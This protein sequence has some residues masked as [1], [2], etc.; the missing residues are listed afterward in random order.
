MYRTVVLIVALVV[1]LML[2]GAAFAATQQVEAEN[3]KMPADGYSI[4]SDTAAS[5][6]KYVNLRKNRTISTSFSGAVD[7]LTVRAKGRYYG[8]AWPRMVVKLDGTTV[9]SRLANS[10]TFQNFTVDLST[11]IADAS[12]NLSLSFTNNYS[13]RDLHVDVVTVDSGSTAPVTA[14]GVNWCPTSPE[15]L[16]LTANEQEMFKLHNQARSQNGVQELCVDSRLVKAAR[17]HAQDMI[18]NDYFSHTSQD[19]R[20]PGD[21]ISAQG[22]KWRTYGENVAYGSGSYGTPQNVFDGW[23]NSE[24]HRANILSSNF[25]DV[26]IGEAIGEY[27]GTQDTHMWVADFGAQ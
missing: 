10:S 1:S 3:M 27:K 16:A 6:G 14:D 13:Y 7:K 25:K 21:R 4:Q 2:G 15:Q 23:M 8:G 18:E 12:H 9:M 22:Y 26:G 19:G 11:N 5:G 17:L 24:G 20:G